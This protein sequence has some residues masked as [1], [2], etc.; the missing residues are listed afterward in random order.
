MNQ[1]AYLFTA[2]LAATSLAVAQ[3]PPGVRRLDPPH[4]ACD[5][6]PV[7][8]DH[9]TVQFDQA[10]DP[11]AYALCGGGP[12]MPRLGSPAWDDA[13]T[14]SIGATLESDHVYSMDLACAESGGF[15][16]ADGLR[17]APMPWRIATRGPALPEGAARAAVDRLFAALREHYSYRDR[18][19]IDWSDLDRNHRER[20]EASPSGAALAL[21]ISD[22]LVSAQDAHISVQ[23]R[24][25]SLPTYRRDVTPN[26]DV[27]G[28]QQVLPKLRKVGN[29]ALVARTDDDIGYLLVGTFARDQRDDFERLLTALR[30][31]RDCK[32]MVLDLRTNS[33]GDEMLAKRLAAYFVEGEVVYAASRPCDPNAP[34]GF[35]ERVDRRL[36]GN[37]APDVF[38][39]PVAVLTG[40][41]CMSSCEAFLLMMKQSPRAVLVGMP[42]FG[43]SGNPAPHQLMTGLTVSLPSWQALRPDGSCF[44][45]EG[46]TPHLYVPTQ[47]Q[48]LTT[49]DPVLE[50]AL[51][52]LRGPR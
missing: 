30:E 1:R 41:I 28:L 44:E 25:A 50:A 15:R 24:D 46:I 48:D 14:F 19:G 2:V 38:A 20:L 7:L 43:S 33:G 16:S 27:R 11:S 8:V 42:S 9:L 47:P 40:P 17:L 49:G 22:L 34:D 12:G 21:R 5:V 29:S 13:K 35:G 10:M 37:E 26:F 39:A 32:A 23:W 18:L 36:R 3:A 31:L 52:R 4:L 51:L 6:D 45:G